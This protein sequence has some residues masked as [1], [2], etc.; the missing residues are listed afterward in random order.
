METLGEQELAVLELVKANPFAGQQ[1]IANALGLARSTVAAHIVQLV[2]KGHILGRGYILPPSRRAV[3]LGG[4]VL[5]RKYHAIDKLSAGTSNP[6]EGFRSPG[7]V[8]RNVAENLALLGTRTSFV[9]ILGNDEP[10]REILRHMRERDIDVSQMQV[11]ER[12]RTAEYAAILDPSGELEL[13]L[14]DMAIFDEFVPTVLDRIWPHL[15]AATWIFADCNLPAATL[16]SLIERKQGARFHLAIDAV[17]TPKVRRLPADLTGIDLIFMNVSEANAF[18][19][20]TGETGIEDARAA[21]LGLQKAGATQ[22]IVSM[23]AA[24][25][26]VAAGDRTAVYPAVRAHPVDMTG[27]G[28]AMI[29][30]TLHR[31]IEGDPLTEA[32]RIGTLLAALTTECPASVNPALSDR[33]L[34]ANLHRLNA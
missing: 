19:G 28:D 17:S 21:A 6:V 24:G 33:F 18:L 1:E 7:G 30:A 29:A 10:G 20:R 16:Q 5:D 34:Q 9:S 4:A 15:A 27:A 14:A 23:G 26:A 13:G 8:A 12:G 2:Q 31:L 3:C 32:A 11:S 25:I 22:A